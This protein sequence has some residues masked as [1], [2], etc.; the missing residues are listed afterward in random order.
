MRLPESMEYTVQRRGNATQDEW[1]SRFRQARQD[2]EESRAALDR[3]MKEL[4]EVGSSTASWKVAPPGLPQAKASPTDVHAD[5]GS[6]L[7]YRL[8]VEIRRHR[9]AIKRAEQGLTDLEIEAN[10][11]GVPEDWR[12]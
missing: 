7:D 11:A 8:N 2:L 3:S 10:L 12:H 5:P 6:P 9:E 4:E 1:R